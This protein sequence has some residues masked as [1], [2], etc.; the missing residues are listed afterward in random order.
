MCFAFC[1]LRL[2]FSVWRFALRH[3]ILMAFCKP[4][5]NSLEPVLPENYHRI[6]T[7]LRGF[8]EGLLL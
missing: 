7:L 4:P 3:V 1:V 5:L 2:A 8:P 6:A